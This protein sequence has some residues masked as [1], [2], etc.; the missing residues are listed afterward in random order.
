M[1]ISSEQPTEI[2][3]DTN[4]IKINLSPPIFVEANLNFNTL[5]LNLKELTDTSSFVCKRTTKG[6]KI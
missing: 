6:V 1:E 2:N 4:T 3:N 5:C